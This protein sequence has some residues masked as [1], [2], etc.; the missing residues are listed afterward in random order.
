MTTEDGREHSG[1]PRG[2]CEVSQPPASARESLQV[3]LPEV[4]PNWEEGNKTGVKVGLG[5]QRGASHPPVP[6]FGR[7]QSLPA[8]KG[9]AFALWMVRIKGGGGGRAPAAHGKLSHERGPP[10]PEPGDARHRPELPPP[11]YSH[12][13]PSAVGCSRSQGLQ[14]PIVAS[15]PMW[16][17]PMC[18]QGWDRDHP[19]T[20]MRA[21][22]PPRGDEVGSEVFL[23]NKGSPRLGQLLR[24]PALS[25]QAG[26]W[27]SHGNL[28]QNGKP[29][30]VVNLF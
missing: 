25:R 6:H 1:T 7:L 3:L 27:L 11:P 22:K 30:V 10:A 28:L 20:G 9:A 15:S 19:S 18:P 14:H 13:I 2:F 29:I 23:L 24:H 26:E 5:R 21:G 8:H 17:S 16:V 4:A 12:G